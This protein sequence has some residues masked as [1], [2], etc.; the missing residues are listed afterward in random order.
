[1]T[2]KKITRREREKLRHQKEI[3][4]SA[5][6]VF[7]QKGFRRATIQDISER[8]EFSIASIYKHFQS[9]EDIYHSLIEQVL[10]V[11]L[12]TLKKSTQNMTDPLEKLYKS[13]ET[14]LK[15]YEEKRAF[16][17]FLFGELRPMIDEEAEQL[18]LKSLNAYLQIVAYFQ[19]LFTEAIEK[20]EVMDVS[21]IYLTISLLG[22]LYAFMNFWLHL[23]GKEIVDE[24]DLILDPSDYDVIP[25]VFFG[26]VALKPR[27]K[28]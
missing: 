28:N 9:K 7:A 5:C 18:S 22:N 14:T 2:K 21:P 16:C 11:F 17:Q 10:A 19:T 1:M 12:K 8:S 6:E 15:M 4:D 23:A 27:K 25:K 13:V 24:K 26:A 3:L 20:K